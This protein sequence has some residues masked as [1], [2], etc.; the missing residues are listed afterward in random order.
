MTINKKIKNYS[1]FFIIILAFFFRIYGI[2]WDN[3]FHLHPDE[4]ML[5]MVADR[6]HFFDQLN[7]NFFNYGSLPIYLLKGSS[8]LADIFFPLKLATYQNMLYV[9]R[10]WSIIFGLLSIFI[11]FKIAYF[12]FNKQVGIWAA[13]FYAIAFFPIQ[14]S[15]FYTVDP[16]LTFLVTLLLYL[17]LNYSKNNN[18]Y[19][20]FLIGLVFSA[21]FSTKFTAIIFYPFIAIFF[22]LISIIRCNETNKKH[23]FLTYLKNFIFNFIIFN[24]SFLIFNFIFMPYAYLEFKKFITDV[25][26]QIKM[27]SD[28]YIFPY[29][30]QYVGTKPYLYYLKNIFWWGLGPVISILSLLGMFL[31]IRCFLVSIFSKKILKLKFNIKNFL[32]T[33]KLLLITFLFYLF[34]FLVIGRSAVKFMR[35]M[36][37]IYPFLAIMAG[38]AIYRIENAKFKIKSYRSKLKTYNFKLSLLTKLIIVIAM[39]WT[40][41]FVNI[42]SQPHT[43][44][45]AT[46]WILKNIPT[47]TTLAVEHWDDRLPL[48]GGERYNFVELTL[49]D[50]PDDF[51]KWQ[52]LTEKLKQTDYIVIA[53]NRLYIPLQ[54]LADCQKYKICYPRTAQYYKKLFK[55][56]EI[57]TDLKF[58]KV[59][60]FEVLPHFSIFGLF[61]SINDQNADESF[62]VYDHP[63][64][65]IFK[66]NKSN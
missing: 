35:Y 22:I 20:L 13:F 11:V 52:I 28:P 55:E 54:K 66:K 7:P 24:F 27:N 58:K 3:G 9:G 46:E 30:L 60:E 17:L 49:Y 57:T 51:Q 8:Q 23:Q 43:R 34:Y 10:F 48:F 53:S 16:I 65:I 63:K 31:S 45:A 42:Y 5:I 50:Q 56:A 18:I 62:T 38:Y 2:N 33:N 25:S 47:G 37:P 41:L 4:R 64:V 36:L 6:I 26:L 44:I 40:L 59:A 39:L 15:N 21:M 61:I 32:I 1:V 14:N 12:L 29:T 19:I